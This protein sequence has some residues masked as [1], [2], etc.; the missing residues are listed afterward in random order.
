[1]DNIYLLHDTEE[2]THY[3]DF[4]LNSIFEQ[5]LQF[6]KIIEFVLIFL[7]LDMTNMH[8]CVFV[9]LVFIM[10]LATQMRQINIS[11]VQ[12]ITMQKWGIQI[13]T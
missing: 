12:H 4:V 10:Y 2:E 7:L 11:W 5:I 1:M 9:F 6:I 13:L 8:F 3:T